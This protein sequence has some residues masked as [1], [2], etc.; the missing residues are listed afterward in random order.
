MVR[1]DRVSGKRVF[2]GAASDD[3]KA[4]VIW[5]AFKP[6]TEP[7][8][9]TRQDAIENKRKEILAL[10]RRGNKAAVDAP[11]QSRPSEKP[12]D[13]VEEQGGLY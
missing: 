4:S 5:E 8:R 9:R 3:P 10:I 6:D 1:I 12:V 7:P 11:K 13:F 2:E